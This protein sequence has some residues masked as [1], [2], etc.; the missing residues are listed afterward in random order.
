MDQNPRI[1]RIKKPRF[2]FD[3]LPSFIGDCNEPLKRIPI[4]NERYNS[5]ECHGPWVLVTVTAQVISS[6]WNI[7][8]NRSFSPPQNLQKTSSILLKKTMGFGE[9]PIILRHTKKQTHE[10]MWKP[11]SS[12]K[13]KTARL[14]QSKR[15]DL[16]YRGRVSWYNLILDPRLFLFC[17]FFSWADYRKICFVWR[18]F[19]ESWNRFDPGD[20]DPNSLQQ[21]PKSRSRHQSL[22]QVHPVWPTSLQHQ[23]FETAQN[24][25]I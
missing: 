2:F 22:K 16:F 18:P 7:C 23:L 15:D 5:R 9:K 17:S 8:L 24:Q 13:T 10:H 3:I 1:A 19:G 11:Q 4:K 12:D 20:F 25:R 14:S 6:I 21:N